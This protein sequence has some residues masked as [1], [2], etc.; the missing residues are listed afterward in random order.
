MV[1]IRVFESASALFLAGQLPGFVHTLHRPGGRRSRRLRALRGGDYITSTHRGH[2]HGI[3]KGMANDVL[4]A[5]LFGKETG[6]TGA[7]GGSMHVADFALG[8]LGANGIVGG[9]FGIAAGAALSARYR[10]SGQVAVCFFG[11]GA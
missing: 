11:D 4:M 5:E 8:M 1:R 9:G 7:R 10:A 3:A 2:G 6:A